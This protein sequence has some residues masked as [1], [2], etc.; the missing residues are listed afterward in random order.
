MT[1]EHAPPSGSRR[2]DVED[3]EV[4]AAGP[5]TCMM[6]KILSQKPTN[7]QLLSVAFLSFLTFAIIQLTF[8][9]IGGSKSLMGDSF[10]MMVD[11]MTYLFNWFAER[12]K[13]KDCYCDVDDDPSVQTI[14]PHVSH[15]NRRKT[16]LFW[17]VIPP[18]ISIVTLFAVTAFIF[19]G[20]ILVFLHAPTTKEEE[21]QAN[22][23][24]MLTFAGINLVLDVLNVGC[25]A[26]AS[27][28][29]GFRTFK[30]VTTTD[31]VYA[32]DC[33]DVEEN[34]SRND[35]SPAI[36]LVESSIS[37][38]DATAKEVDDET[39]MKQ[40]QRAA[41]NLNMC[42][43]YTHV[44][45][46]T[47]R[48]LAVIIAALVARHMD[49]VSPDQADAAAAIAVSI[50]I[51]LSVVPLLTGLKRSACEWRAIR[52]AEEAEQAVAAASTHNGDS[53]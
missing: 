7:Q 40:P 34:S 20:S 19:H 11:A 26:R 35:D 2:N 38:I 23:T 42:S 45:A 5:G 14:C 33:S 8:S 41:A 4:C 27:H 50:L 32:D 1:K 15:R 12:R 46:D 47:L 17:E 44:F 10:T 49:T 36:T 37:V 48:S 16:N 52:A 30:N 9:F 18:L 25:F 22:T 29:F 21:K 39:S 31:E 3:I 6:G 24:I 13:T 28:V 51:L 43:A 53:S